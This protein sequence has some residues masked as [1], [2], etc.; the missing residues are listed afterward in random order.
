MTADTL[1]STNSN[2]VL[3]DE[4]LQEG[5]MFDPSMMEDVDLDGMDSREFA[6]MVAETA[7]AFLPAEANPNEFV[8]RYVAMVTPLLKF[9]G[10]EK[11][12]AGM[13][14]G[15]LVDRSPWIG[16]I[17][18]SAATVLGLWV[19]WP[20]IQQPELAPEQI[21]QIR[22]YNQEQMSQHIDESG[23]EYA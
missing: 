4:M 21:E 5:A 2:E 23:D 13:T 6:T 9:G 17:I 15:G 8:R 20:K 14:L 3:T 19:C 12:T 11:L 18:C 7:S 1:P 16:A 10:F 22:A